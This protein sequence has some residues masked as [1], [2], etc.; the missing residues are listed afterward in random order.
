[1]RPDPDPG[2]FNDDNVPSLIADVSTSFGH[3]TPDRVQESYVWGP[4]EL[5]ETT[6][7]FVQPRGHGLF[8][9]LSRFVERAFASH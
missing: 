9:E 4:A 3:G 2:N 7:E 6:V 1:M 8:S 5:R